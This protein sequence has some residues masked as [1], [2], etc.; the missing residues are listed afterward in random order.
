[1]TRWV[2]EWGLSQCLGLTQNPST[3]VSPENPRQHIN[4]I[5]AFIDGS[6]VYGYDEERSQW[7][8]AFHGGKL[9]TSK[10][11]LLPFNTTTGEFNDPVDPSAPEMD[12]PVNPGSK[13]F[14][15]G[16]NRANEN[17]LLISFHTL[18]VREHNR[19]CEE[20][21]E[22][23]PSWNDERLYQEAK[24]IN[25]GLIQ[26]IVYNEWLPAMGIT[27]EEYAGYKNDVNPGIF[28]VFSAAAYRLG[29]TLINGT[30]RRL[31]GNGNEI[32]R[33]HISLRDAFF[34]PTEILLGGGIEPLIKGMG[35]QVQQDLD[36]KV[37]DDVRN[38]LFGPPGAGG[39]D[40]AAINI[41]RGRERGIPD[42]NSVRAGIGLSPYEDFSE[43]HSDVSITTALQEVFQDINNIDPWVGMLAEEHMHDALVGPT[44][45]RI[46]QL[47]F[48]NLRDGD[49]FY[50]MNDPDL[51][52][53][54]KEAI[55]QTKFSDIIK[56]NTGISL[57]QDNVF[58]A[59]PH[60]EIPKASIELVER[61]LEAVLYP[62]PVQEDLLFVKC[63]SILETEGLYRIISQTG[64]IVLEEPM[65][66]NKGINEF[67]LEIPDRLP[68]GLYS[69]Y[70]E[71]GNRYKSH[72]FVKLEF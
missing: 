51:P 37:I 63:Y 32:D 70:L 62:N 69:L 59:M 22:S 7:L 36:C 71:T 57:M 64:R 72:K 52:E 35:T 45:M 17:L 24:R 43:I 33:K 2:Q 29:H 53:S 65:I 48:E 49:R 18:F 9:K 58:E 25:S 34:N 61:H 13:V 38:F 11:N 10:N 6:A 4:S 50:Y 60:G 42:L 19:L 39:L 23:N 55:N 30:L 27:L 14:V 66:F 46:L 16:D 40:L 56:R 31:D 12:N 20:L 67:E 68:A 8:R 41:Q 5:T 1:M 3:G 26:A 47:Q 21:K 54:W 28:N 15:A 44:I